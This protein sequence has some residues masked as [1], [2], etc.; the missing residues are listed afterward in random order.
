MGS[1]VETLADLVPAQTRLACVGINP[2][3]ISVAA[4]HY[5]RGPLGRRL[6]D[7]L[8]QVGLLP[9]QVDGWDDDDAC[10]RGVGFTDIVKRPTRSSSEVTRAELQ[11]GA[12]ILAG[13]LA[14]WEAPLA[15]FAFKNV[16]MHLFGRFEGNG[17]VAGLRVGVSDVYVMLWPYESRHKVDHTLESLRQWLEDNPVSREPS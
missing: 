6:F 4:G 9:E 1:P 8:R 11:Y 10:E 5:Y 7:R 3:P 12:E 14:T 2:A 15:V 16:A 13:K 17:F